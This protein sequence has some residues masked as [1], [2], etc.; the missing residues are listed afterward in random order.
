MAVLVASASA[1]RVSASSPAPRRARPR[2]GAASA[3]SFSSPN[4][5]S[6]SSPALFRALFPARVTPGI[7]PRGGATPAHS[8]NA[9]IQPSAPR[10]S[11]S[12]AASA[13]LTR[14][15]PVQTSNSPGAAPLRTVAMEVSSSVTASVTRTF[16][17][18]TVHVA[19]RTP[20]TSHSSM[21]NR[22]PPAVMTAIRLDHP[23]PHRTARSG[24][25]GRWGGWF[26]SRRTPE[27]KIRASRDARDSGRRSSS[28]SGFHLPRESRR[29]AC[30]SARESFSQRMR[31][32]TVTTAVPSPRSL[33]S[34]FSS[35]SS[36]SS[37]RFRCRPD[38]EATSTRTVFRHS[39]TSSSSSHLAY[40][41]TKSHRSSSSSLARASK[42]TTSA[43][44]TVRTVRP[45]ASTST[46]R[47]PRASTR[48]KRVAGS[49]VAQPNVRTISGGSTPASIVDAPRAAPRRPFLWAVRSPSPFKFV[50]R[51][52]KVGQTK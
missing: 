2:P 10:G 11:E 24:A 41:S 44:S 3:C 32:S 22:R 51:S 46:S 39:R 23:P 35:S 31:Y 38:A 8:L 49:S 30:P 5:E 20:S 28:R 19:F 25:P 7:F 6:P 29:I 36:S 17:P 50:A 26:L 9:S 34:S 12:S 42:L 21:R 45:R 15:S 37:S 1:A 27:V 48:S 40:S 18:Y 33:P 14:P 47:S 13:S 4:A 43:T 16:A 52:L